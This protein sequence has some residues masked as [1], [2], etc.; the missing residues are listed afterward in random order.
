MQ[1]NF[2]NLPRY[3]RMQ[4]KMAS[5]SPDQMAIVD[6]LIADKQFASEQMRTELT[7]MRLAR[8]KKAGAQSI[9]RAR[10]VLKM[11]DYSS[12][13]LKMKEGVQD[14]TKKQNRL[15]EYL[16]WGNVLAST[17]LGIAKSSVL[18]KLAKQTAKLRGGLNSWPLL[19]K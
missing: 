5:Y 10:H 19:A 17:G 16:G 18:S 7:G 8:Q 13:R 1:Y 11:G 15:G 14:W 9:K 12:D 4:Q 3:Q 6:S 2:E